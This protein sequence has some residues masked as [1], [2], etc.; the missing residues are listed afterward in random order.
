[1]GNT[2]I[3]R[4]SAVDAA[5]QGPSAVRVFAVVYIAVPAEE[6]LSTEGFYVDGYPVAGFYVVYVCTDLFYDTHH[7][8]AY[9]NAGYGTRYTSVL[10]VEVAG[11]DTS[12]GDA[13]QSILR[14]FQLRN[15]FLQQ[16]ENL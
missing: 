15:G 14:V 3:F 2:D 11:A 4:L 1:M 10:D 5:T 7:F 8:M 6:A 13:Y 16:G 9:R 12:Q